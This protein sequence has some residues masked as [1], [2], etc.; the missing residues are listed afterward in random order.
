MWDLLPAEL[1]EKVFNYLSYDSISQ[2][3]LTCK[4]WAKVAQ[5]Q[6]YKQVTLS[7]CNIEKF[8][9]TIQSSA[10]GML[11]KKINLNNKNNSLFN[12]LQYGEYF[13]VIPTLSVHCPFIES[14]NISHTSLS[15][16]FNFKNARDSNYWPRL[17]E[18][19]YPMEANEIEYYTQIALGLRDS[20]ESLLLCDQLSYAEDN[21]L[22]LYRAEYDALKK[23]LS[24]FH[25]LKKLFIRMHTHESIEDIDSVFEDCLSL[26]ILN[27]NLYYSNPTTTTTITI[28]TSHPLPFEEEEE[29]CFT[30]IVPSPTIFSLELNSVI[31]TNRVYP[32]IMH[33]F[34]SLRR[35]YVNVACDDRTRQLM[36]LTKPKFSKE[37]IEHLYHY[38]SNI[39]D[40]YLDNLHVSNITETI[41]HW[42]M[43]ARR[44]NNRTLRIMY[45]NDRLNEVHHENATH[46]RLY[47]TKEDETVDFQENNHPLEREGMM[48]VKLAVIFRADVDEFSLPHIELI[49]KIG[50]TSSFTTLDLDMKQKR[51]CRFMADNNNDFLNMISGYYLDHLFRT[52]T[53]LRTLILRGAFL[54]D[55]APNTD[56]SQSIEHLI[57]SRCRI[58]PPVLY[59]LS[60]RLPLLKTLSFYCWEF[61][62]VDGR[63]S[64]EYI[65][66][67]LM[68]DMPYSSLHTIRWISD[69]DQ[70][71]N[72]ADVFYLRVCTI[73]KESYYRGDQNRLYLTSAQ[74][75]R[76]S[77]SRETTMTFYIRCKDIKIFSLY[78]KGFHTDYELI[79]Q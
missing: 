57:L 68:V 20:L 48:M 55:C 79:N 71:R 73:R 47:T 61:V 39:E 64:T 42:L 5:P 24:S 50:H 37:F 19:P 31:H 23:E 33:K 13:N 29:M 78:H 9:H 25:R 70:R 3:Q 54:L 4:Q 62:T 53:S 28:S 21:H 18:I 14:F 72:M 51:V 41:Y 32:Y 49:D 58:H 76:H 35:L 40:C 16:W 75:Y 34:P 26:K 69:D 44:D 66:Q 56:T 17:K 1:L 11:V 77:M 45:E 6:L 52:C 63:N 2:C 27:V 8:K 15:F 60:I 46:L 67:S 12:P 43:T 7:T 74:A 38:I 59:Q 22:S 30:H 36:R 65:E 10:I